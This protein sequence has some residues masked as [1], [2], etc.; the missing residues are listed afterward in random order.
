METG[1]CCISCRE[2][3]HYRNM[4]SRAGA[5]E[6]RLWVNPGSRVVCLYAKGEG[7]ARESSLRRSDA[8]GLVL[9]LV[10]CV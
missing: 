6:A 4:L 8:D 7:A 1:W 9:Y 5:G 10:S 2:P 3:A